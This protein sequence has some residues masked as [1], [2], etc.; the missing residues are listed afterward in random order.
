[1][2]KY[3]NYL[4]TG[5]GI[6]KGWKTKTSLYPKVALLAGILV[7]TGFAWNAGA[8]GKKPQLKVGAYY[9]D[10]WAGQN[11]KASDPNEPWAKNA[12]TNLSRRM[13]EEFPEREPVWGW[14]DDSQAIMERQIDLAADNGIE[15]FLFCWY[16]RDSNG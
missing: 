14:R 5:A 3:S 8:Q 6:L 2:K 7:L 9:F 10:G 11:R 12:P 13:V 1:M 4:F 15:F 16:W